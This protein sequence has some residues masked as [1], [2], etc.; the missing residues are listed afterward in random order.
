MMSTALAAVLKVTAP[1][2]NFTAVDVAVL[3]VAVLDPVPSCVTIR[4]M[5]CPVLR[6]VRK[7]SVAP[8]RVTV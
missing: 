3:N 5:L 8:V 7:K 6:L 2:G 1:P 4:D